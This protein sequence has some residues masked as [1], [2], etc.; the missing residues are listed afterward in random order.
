M[1]KIKKSKKVIVYEN[2]K[3]L[4]ISNSLK[5][6]DALNEILLAKEMKT[7]K[8]PIREAIQQLEKD[9]LVENIRG[10]G[11]FVS[12]FSFQDIRELTEIREILECDVIRKVA[13]RGEFDVSHVAEIRRKFETGEANDSKNTKSYISAGDQIHLFIFT[14]HGN[15]RLLEYYRR[16]HEH[17]T[18]IRLYQYNKVDKERALES[19]REHLEIIDALIAMDPDR[20]ELAMRRHLHNALDYLKSII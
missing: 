9:G 6:G 12:R 13:A 14:A 1:V 17:I 3:R 15:A 5:P 18:R 2:L 16:L 4:I 20:A 11:A 8:T 19:F 10:R 7:S